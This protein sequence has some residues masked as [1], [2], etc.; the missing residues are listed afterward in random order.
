MAASSAAW[1]GSAGLV[2]LVL[3]LCKGRFVLA[4]TVKRVSGRIAALPAP[5]RFGAVYTKSYWLLIGAMMGLGFLLRFAPLSY[6]A[7]GCI[8]ITIGSALILGAFLYFIQAWRNRSGS[9][10]C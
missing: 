2:A 6:E 4:K 7:R 1:A 9:S 5:I 8:D 3:G 10:P